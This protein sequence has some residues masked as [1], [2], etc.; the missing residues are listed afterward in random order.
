MKFCIAL[1]KI[2]GSCRR[3]NLVQ[4]VP[5]FTATKSV[6]LH[7]GVRLIFP[8]HTV[9]PAADDPR[10]VREMR[11]VCRG[12]FV[13]FKLLHETYFSCLALEVVIMHETK[14]FSRAIRDKIIVRENNRITKCV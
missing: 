9:K 5:P 12:Y 7:R 14:T 4:D 11:H 2:R 13:F 3:V 1:F 8:C 10:D 6:S